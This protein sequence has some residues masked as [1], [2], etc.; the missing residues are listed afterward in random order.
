MPGGGALTEAVLESIGG[1]RGIA[2]LSLKG[3]GIMVVAT[4]ATFAF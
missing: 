3:A 1:V 2:L 4:L